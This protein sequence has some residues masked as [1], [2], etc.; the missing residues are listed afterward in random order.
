[1]ISHAELKK[2]ALSKPGVKTAYDALADEYMLARE[3]LHAREVAGLTQAEVANRMHTKPPAI[4]RL[5]GRLAVEIGA[6]RRRGGRGVGDLLR[7]GRGHANVL[8][9]DAEFV[10][11]NAHGLFERQTIDGRTLYFNRSASNLF[12]LSADARARP[13]AH[14]SLAA[15]MGPVSMG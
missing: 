11:W 15:S 9:A 8:E 1:M 6:G 5:E 4:A 12:R 3:L 14:S 7:V 13:W 2:K 10:R